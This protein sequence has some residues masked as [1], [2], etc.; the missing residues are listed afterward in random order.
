MSRLFVLGVGPLPFEERIKVYGS[1]LRT[2]HFI[3][4]LLDQGHEIRLVAMQLPD[5]YHEENLPQISKIERDN[6]SYYSVNELYVFMDINYLQMHCDEFQPDAI[7]GINTH[8]AAQACKLKTDK[9][10]WADLN[11]WVMAEAQMKAAI[12][13]DDNFLNYFWAQEEPIIKRADRFS[14]VSI[15]QKY[16][17]I[18][19]LAAFGRLNRRTFGYDFVEHIPNA[20]NSDELIIGEPL[21][22]GKKVQDDDF[23][24]LWS[25]GYNTWTDV[26]TLFNGLQEAMSQNPRIKFISTGGN[27]SGHDDFT[28]RDFQQKIEQSPYKDRFILLG[29][30]SSKDIPTVYSE[31]DLG[32]NIDGLNYE[33]VFG[34]RNRLNS[35]LRS[36]I[37]VLTTLGTEVTEILNDHQLAL[38][39][40]RGNPKSLAEQIL[41]AAQHRGEIKSMGAQGQTFVLSEWSRVKT[42]LAVQAWAKNP[43]HSPDWNTKRVETDAAHRLIL[44]ESATSKTTGGSHV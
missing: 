31:C 21:L 34:A 22:R 12:Y 19:E 4:P 9:P 2:W 44:P 37:P 10:I 40:E 35:M 39:F 27:I 36:G 5:P 28:Y 23:L 8:A 6:L 11:G 26:D 17:L 16:A 14:T 43:T 13:K 15:P 29:W 20:V 33:V 24:V 25:G 18:G 41:W 38:S 1:S 32:L 42:T 7:L 3:Q 30:I